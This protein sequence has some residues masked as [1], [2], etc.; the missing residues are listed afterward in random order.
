MGPAERLTAPPLLRT[1]RLARATRA[2]VRQGTVA[3]R[4][5]PTM[6]PPPRD[7]L[8]NRHARAVGHVSDRTITGKRRGGCHCPAEAGL[9]SDDE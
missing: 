5:R 9:A 7:V 6:A 2:D 3:R 1:T 8:T 4:Y